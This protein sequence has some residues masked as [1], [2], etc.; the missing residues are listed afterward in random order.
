MHPCAAASPPHP[1]RPRGAEVAAAFDR[2]LRALERDS[3]HGSLVAWSVAA[4]VLAA[5][6]AWFCLGEVTLFAVSRTARIEVRQAAHPLSA[7]VAGRVVAS[8][9]E[10][11]RPVRAGETVV[12]FDTAAERLRLREEEARLD[13]FQPRLGS[14][15]QEILL[16]EQTDAKEQRTALAA[17]LVAR[18]RVEEADAAVEFARENERGLRE[19]SVAGSVPKID[20]QRAAADLRRLAATRDALAAEVRR[21]EADAQARAGTQRAE[22]EALRRQAVVLEGE[23]ATTRATVAR[24]RNEIDRQK[25]VAPVDGRI[26]DIAGV[27]IGTY[28]TAGQSIGSV[29]PGGGVLLVAEFDPAAVI[30]RIRIGQASRLRLD[31]FPWAQYGLVDATVRR[32][33][34]EV[35]GTHLRVEFDLGSD[36]SPHVAL[37]H[38]QPGSVEVALERVTPAQLVLRTAGQW[39]SGA[40]RPAHADATSRQ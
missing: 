32:I 28:V 4:L 24:L 23:L 12:E 21:I 25:V 3:G 39:L 10:I 29:V 22:I 27:R 9:L 34:G 2:T 18:H 16:R 31:G 19:E 8:A 33:A 38:G 20:A 6:T 40:G 1:S 30:G 37:R 36:P 13:A 15:R 7:P 26:G 14:V 11:G 35:R 5:W 17:R